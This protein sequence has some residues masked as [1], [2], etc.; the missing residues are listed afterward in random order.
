MTGFAVFP[1]ARAT[2]SV[3]RRARAVQYV[4]NILD[5]V[6]RAVRLFFFFEVPPTSFFRSTP[7]YPPSRNFVSA[8]LVSLAWRGAGAGGVTTS[9]MQA[10]VAL[11]RLGADVSLCPAKSQI[12]TCTSSSTSLSVPLTV[13]RFENA[14]RTD[15]WGVASRHDGHRAGPVRAGGRGGIHELSRQQ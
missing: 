7:L 11:V 14:V 3:R 6:I 5:T 13:S 12:N 4:H 9:A 8:E 2:R 1:R 10:S 15:G